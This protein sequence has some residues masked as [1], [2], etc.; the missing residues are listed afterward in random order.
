MTSCYLCRLTP[1]AIQ[2]CSAISASFSRSGSY[3]KPFPSP[4]PVSIP[5]PL[6][7]SCWYNPFVG[8]WRE[9]AGGTASGEAQ[10]TLKK[11]ALRFL[12]R[13]SSFAASQDG[14]RNCCGKAAWELMSSGSTRHCSWVHAGNAGKNS[15]VM[16]NSPWRTQKY[17]RKKSPFS[18]ALKSF[19]FQG[20]YALYN[21]F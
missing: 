7:Q 5:V 10:L 21:G 12:I 17:E 4:L 11:E 20:Y 6:P 8:L 3:K 15:H 16:A 2:G 19:S 18:N 1:P 9:L 13:A 14:G